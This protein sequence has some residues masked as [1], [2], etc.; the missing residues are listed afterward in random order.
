MDP[1]LPDYS[2]ACVSRVVPE[3]LGDRG[4]GWLPD[5]V[6]EA[7]S[8]VLLVLDGLGWEALETHP[9]ALGEIRSLEGGPISTVVPSTTAAALTSIA[10]GLAP[11]EHGL[12][13]F[14]M[15]WDHS[16][17]NNLSWQLTPRAQAPDPLDVQ[18]HAAFGR[19][20]V[21][22]VTASEYRGSGFT[23]AQL[24]GSRFVGWST[25]AVLVEQIRHLV[26]AGERFVHA[27][28]PGIDKVA[29]EFGLRDGYYE[30]ELAAADALVARLRAAID[31]DA[32]LVITSDHGQV[33]AEEGDWYDLGALSSLVG[34]QAG[35][36]RFR[37]L[38]ANDG[39]ATELAAAARDVFA[40]QAWVMTRAELLDAGWLGP[41]PSGSIGSRIGDVILAAKGRAAFIDPAL[42]REATLRS[43]HGS[44]TAAEMRV[45]LVT[46]RG[47]APRG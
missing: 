5:G 28:Y 27:Y 16:V 41:R 29:H 18:R 4:A 42:P 19:R 34:M 24:R 9:A 23:E 3:L 8:V 22:A 26:T 15:R 30:A 1:S 2:G 47:T 43:L 35:D 31:P 38:Y 39:A 12:V 7:K 32:A 33:H 46:G 10:T 40:S 17:L 45:P 13:G 25:P 6:R 37:Y 36:A 11:S 44:V 21:P 20:A 14:R